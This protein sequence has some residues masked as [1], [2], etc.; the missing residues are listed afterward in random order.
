MRS[1][2]GVRGRV[3]AEI[4]VRAALPEPPSFAVCASLVS[5]QSVEEAGEAA[6]SSLLT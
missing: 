3:Q 2:S 6:A 1:I 4:Y 5:L